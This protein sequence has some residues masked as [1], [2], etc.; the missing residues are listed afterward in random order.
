MPEPDFATTP[1]EELR[2]LALSGSAV[3]SQ[4]LR[5]MTRRA[6]DLPAEAPPPSPPEPATLA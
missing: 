5:E 1:L 6:Y 3:A 4:A 2:G